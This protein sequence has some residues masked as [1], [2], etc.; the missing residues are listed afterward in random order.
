[1]GF[2]LIQSKSN[3]Q[4]SVPADG[5]F[6]GSWKSTETEYIIFKSFKCQTMRKCGFI[7]QNSREFIVFICD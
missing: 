2:N 1:M 5:E 7:N 3:T 4:D 6:V